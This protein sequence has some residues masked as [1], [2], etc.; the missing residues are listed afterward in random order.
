VYGKRWLR[1]LLA[2]G[3]TAQVP[4][5]IPEALAGELPMFR[6]IKVRMIAEV[7][8]KEDQSESSGHALKVMALGRVVSP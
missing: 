7:D 5:Y 1:A 2:A 6:R 4:V 3:T 8:L